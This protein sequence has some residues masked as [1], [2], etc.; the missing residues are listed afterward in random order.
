MGDGLN[1]PSPPLPSPIAEKLTMRLLLCQ[2]SRS[3]IA[4][5]LCQ[6]SRSSIANSSCHIH[7]LF[8]YVYVQVAIEICI[9]RQMRIAYIVHTNCVH[10]I[11]C[12][13]DLSAQHSLYVYWCGLLYSTG[14]FQKKLQFS[15]LWYLHQ[16]SLQYRL[17]QKYQHKLKATLWFKDE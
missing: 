17:F 7:V 12:T 6:M 10:C 16:V 5:F 11:Y 4:F 2:M 8:P 13:K 3:S 15:P 14:C 1:P 9:N